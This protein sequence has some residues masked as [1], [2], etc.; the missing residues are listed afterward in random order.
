MSHALISENWSRWW[1]IYRTNQRTWRT[2]GSNYYLSWDGG[3]EPMINVVN[4]SHSC[5]TRMM[6]KGCAWKQLCSDR[7]K[8]IDLAD[9]LFGCLVTNL[10]RGLKF[11]LFCEGKRHITEMFLCLLPLKGPR[12]TCPLQWIAV[13]QC[14]SL[15]RCKNVA[16]AFRLFNIYQGKTLFFPDNPNVFMSEFYCLF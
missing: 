4:I 5:Y 13:N 14:E 12:F 2:V 16:G 11:K 6:C 9:L 15:E 3:W 10:D 7:M 8:S 1:N